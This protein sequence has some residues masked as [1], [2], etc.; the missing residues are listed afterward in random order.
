MAA[1]VFR[2]I[3]K[4][5]IKNCFFLKNVLVVLRG[6]R[7]LFNSDV[8]KTWGKEGKLHLKFAAF[9]CQF[10]MKKRNVFPKNFFALV[11]LDK[12]QNLVPPG[13]NDII[14][15]VITSRSKCP[16][17]SLFSY[18]STFNFCFFLSF[19]IEGALSNI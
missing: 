18:A 1:N 17:V 4:V 9:F 6:R 8:T 13:K 19:N 12:D 15:K 11:D 7:S 2:P 5:R 14:Q 10:G 3:Q 16:S